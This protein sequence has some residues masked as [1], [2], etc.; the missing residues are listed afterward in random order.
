MAD[1]ADFP[2]LTA[3]SVLEL[4]GRT[5]LVRLRRVIPPESAAVWAKLER[6]NPAGCVKERIALSMIEAAE[7]DGRLKPGGV[8]VEPTSGNTGIGLAMVAAVKGYR[9][10]LVMPDSLSRER[11]DLMRAY[12]ADLVLTPAAEG[13]IQAAIA[14]AKDIV[15]NMPGAFMPMQFENP[16]NPAAHE[17]TTGPEILAQAPGPVAA[18]V[19]GSGTG[20][21]ITGTGRALKA[22][23]PET[24]VVAVQP[25]ESP[26]LGGGAPGSHSI[27]GIGPSFIPPVIDLSVIDEIMSVASE[28]A[29]QMTRDLARLEGLLVGISSGAATVA[30]LRIAAR[31]RPDQHV[32]VLLPDTGE[33]YL[34]TGVFGVDG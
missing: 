8:I 25:A 16:A 28:E 32:V 21:A 24:L 3:G 1:Y 17:Q 20:G 31:F 19:A 22:A 12:G 18:F 29:R 2:G 26:V 30:A 6:Q 5:P 33:R 15:R 27:Q 7:R 14:K 4:I 11:R 13:G 10:I 23:N 34:S 9:A